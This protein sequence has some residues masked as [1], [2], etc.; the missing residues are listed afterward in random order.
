MTFTNVKIYEAMEA[1]LKGADELDIVINL[2]EVKANNWH[3]VKKEISDIITATPK[4]YTK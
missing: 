3:S 4:V 2:C 1:V